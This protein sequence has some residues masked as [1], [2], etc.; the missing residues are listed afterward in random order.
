MI[1]GASEYLTT[2]CGVKTSVGSERTIREVREWRVKKWGK[3]ERNR[4]NGTKGL[5]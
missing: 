1:S 4:S 3:L 5:L 2:D